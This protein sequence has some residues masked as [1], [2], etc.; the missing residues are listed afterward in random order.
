[1]PGKII[2]QKSSCKLAATATYA[3]AYILE[4][5]VIAMGDYAGGFVN[6]AGTYM[7]AKLFR[8]LE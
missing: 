1:M 8:A 5:P 6:F 7:P 4:N 2:L 3:S